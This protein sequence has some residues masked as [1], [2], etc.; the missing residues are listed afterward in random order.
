MS[1]VVVAG[2]F[3][4]AAKVFCISCRTFRMSLSSLTVSCWGLVDSGIPLA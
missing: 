1:R 2:Y 3:E 4:F